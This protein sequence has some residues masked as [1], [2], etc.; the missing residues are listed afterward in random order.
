MRILAA[1]LIVSFAFAVDY[2]YIAVRV[3]S[4]DPRTGL[5]KVTGIAGSCEGK[6]FNLIAKPGMDPKQ[7]EK[8]ELRVL[9]DSDHCEDK[10]TYKIL[11]R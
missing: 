7:I 4:Y 1:L 9:I 8:R 2:L 3:E 6:S 10:A 11:E 5:M